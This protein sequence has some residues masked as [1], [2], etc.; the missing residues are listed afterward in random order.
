MLCLLHGMRVVGK[1][2]RSK[3]DIQAVAHAALKLPD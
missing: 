3:K 2:G 1:A